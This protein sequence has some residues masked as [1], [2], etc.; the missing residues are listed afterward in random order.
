M[1]DD[2][3]KLVRAV[4]QTL[5]NQNKQTYEEYTTFLV[6]EADAQKQI[7]ISYFFRNCFNYSGCQIM[8]QHY[9]CSTAAV[10]S[11][12]QKHKDNH[13][14]FLKAVLK[15]KKYKK[16]FTAPMYQWFNSFIFNALLQ[17]N[18]SKY[19]VAFIEGDTSHIIQ[20]KKLVMPKVLYCLKVQASVD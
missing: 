9:G 5:A 17:A 14:D 18:I 10:Y 20:G 3:K 12:W 2:E 15:I 16:S 19:R 11:C 6:A 13:N 7:P 8:A 4:V 1:T